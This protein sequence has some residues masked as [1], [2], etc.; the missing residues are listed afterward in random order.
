MVEMDANRH[1]FRRRTYGIG[2]TP[3]GWQGW[4][5]TL[6]AVGAV[7]AVFVTMRHSAVRIPVVVAIL[8]VYAGIALATGGTRAGRDR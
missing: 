4:L 2:F 3:A 6:V 7:L 8:G 5:T 1:W